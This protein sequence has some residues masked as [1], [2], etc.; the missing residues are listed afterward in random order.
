MNLQ[1]FF[2][3]KSLDIP[4]KVV[5]T[6]FGNNKK[7]YGG[8][9][10]ND[11]KITLNDMDAMAYYRLISS[12]NE[13]P[14]DDRKHTVEISLSQNVLINGRFDVQAVV[15]P[16]LALENRDIERAILEIW[17]ATPLTYEFYEGT[18]PIEYHNTVM[19]IVN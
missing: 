9:C 12:K 3:A 13:G 17:E 2:L 5:S 11:L 8:F 10:K 14:L 6:F 18:N 4:T 15:L 16:N 19:Q 7:Y 1:K